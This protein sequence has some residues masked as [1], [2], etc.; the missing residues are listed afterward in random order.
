MEDFRSDAR[1]GAHIGVMTAFDEDKAEVDVFLLVESQTAEDE[2]AAVE[3]SHF[4][5]FSVK[6]K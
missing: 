1:G 3:A 4:E 6:A 2:G 5:S